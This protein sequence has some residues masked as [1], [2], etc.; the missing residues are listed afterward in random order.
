MKISGKDGY[1]WAG[2]GIWKGNH[3]EII[4]NDIS[5]MEYWGIGFVGNFNYIFGNNISYTFGG[6][7]QSEDYGNLIF[8][9][10]ILNCRDRGIQISSD[11]KNTTVKW[12][13]VEFS[14][15]GILIYGAINTKI[16]EN[17][18]SYNDRGISVVNSL[19]TFVIHNNFMNNTALISD[20]HICLWYENYWDDWH[21]PLPRPIIG[22]IGII[23]PIPWFQFDW[24]PLMQ[25]YEW[26]KG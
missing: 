26:W 4:N 14:R 8:S 10:K 16:L 21:I 3:N 1:G 5:K 6:G 2:I 11:S 23:F 25:P 24:H 19:L 7:I 22:E 13:I 18:F 17:N 9:N 15:T 12:N 20:A